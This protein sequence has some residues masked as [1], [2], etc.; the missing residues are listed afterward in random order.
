[1]NQCKDLINDELGKIIQADELIS[2]DS[3]KIIKTKIRVKEELDTMQDT[4]FVKFYFDILYLELT[5]LCTNLF[6]HELTSAYCKEI[7]N[8]FESQLI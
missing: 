2:A 7:L 3:E 6:Y 8:G 4:A 1:M 5:T